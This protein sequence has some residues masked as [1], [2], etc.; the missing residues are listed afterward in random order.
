MK[1]ILNK[2]LW[3]ADF[4]MKKS[5]LAVLL[6]LLGIILLLVIFPFDK[7][8]ETLFPE[9]DKNI[10]FKE[11]SSAENTPLYLL[12]LEGERLNLYLGEE[13][14]VPFESEIVRKEVFPKDDIIRLQKG[15][16]FKNKEDAYTAMENFVN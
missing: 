2:L 13:K 11:V 6:I 4:G 10:E 1:K 9:N 16:L 12:T 15:M 7:R 8:N 14:N 3:K 5:V